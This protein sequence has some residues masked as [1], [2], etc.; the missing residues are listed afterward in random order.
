MPVTGMP[1]PESAAVEESG[2]TEKSEP[3]SVEA[4]ARPNRDAE[5]NWRTVGPR[6]RRVTVTRRG[7]A[8]RFNHI[9]TGV[10]ARSS[11]KRECEHRQCYQCKSFC[12]VDSLVLSGALNPAISAKLPKKM[13]D[14]QI[15]QR[16]NKRATQDGEQLLA[17]GTFSFPL[18]E[19]PASSSKNRWSAAT[20]VERRPGQQTPATD[21]IFCPTAIGTHRTLCLSFDRWER[22]ETRR[23][24]PHNVVRWGIS[25]RETRGQAG[26]YCVW[27]APGFV[28]SRRKYRGLRPGDPWRWVS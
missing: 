23:S 11:S 21:P 15:T 4:I 18:S 3:R 22:N 26:H 12:H 1:A 17:T 19:L 24:K 6:W 20:D 2:T 25:D 16:L 14:V 5:S 7:C 28:A 27:R 9:G 13:T 8:L 10:R